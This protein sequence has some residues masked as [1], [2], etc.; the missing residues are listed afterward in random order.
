M[1]VLYKHT[2][3]RVQGQFGPILISRTRSCTRHRYLYVETGLIDVRA[4]GRGACLS[5][6]GVP[7][8]RSPARNTFLME[9]GTRSC[10]GGDSPEAAG[11]CVC[12]R[13]PVL[14]KVAH[15][16]KGCDDLHLGK[17]QHVVVVQH[18][19][20]RGL[21]CACRN[22]L[23]AF[24]RDPHRDHVRQ[25]IE[26]VINTA[27]SHHS[28]QAAQER[29]ILCSGVSVHISPPTGQRIGAGVGGSRPGSAKPPGA[30]RHE[31]HIPTGVPQ[32]M[33]R[34]PDYASA[35]L[36]PPQPTKVI[37]ESIAEAIRDL[38]NPSIDPLTKM[39]S[40]KYLASHGIQ[41]GVEELKGAGS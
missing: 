16:S 3:A 4:S 17:H 31:Q 27:L 19:L 5:L 18:S 33:K 41:Y 2:P 21:V 26:H 14:K 35:R 13:G 40:R 38:T 8:A 20:P 28:P 1:K 24:V 22:Q 39:L 25:C 10:T 36:K 9:V 29:S 6:R 23:I 12:W 11:G 32:S 34:Q 15:R 30:T 7:I 37:S